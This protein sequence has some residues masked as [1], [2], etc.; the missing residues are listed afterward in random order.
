VEV[1]SDLRRGCGSSGSLNNAI[2]EYLDG[3]L[4][5]KHMKPWLRCGTKHQCKVVG[6]ETVTQEFFC[7]QCAADYGLSW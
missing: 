4:K 3:L 1:P 6:G 2:Y 7:W 5:Q